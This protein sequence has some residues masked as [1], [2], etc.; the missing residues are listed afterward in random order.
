MA[1]ET[2]V[3]LILSLHLRSAAIYCMYIYSHIY[4]HILSCRV[5]ECDVIKFNSAFHDFWLLPF[6]RIRIYLSFLVM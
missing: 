1:R 4:C 5:R 6:I 3:H 2:S